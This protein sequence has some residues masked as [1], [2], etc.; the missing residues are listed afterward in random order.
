V[1][2]MPQWTTGMR[3]QRPFAEGALNG[4]N[5]PEVRVPDRSRYGR[6]SISWSRDRLLC[7]LKSLQGA[8]ALRSASAT[9]NDIPLLQK[10]SR[11]KEAQPRRGFHLENLG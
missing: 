10:G 8:E 9:R 7:C 6:G 3:K 5:R 4:S 1:R 2:M 11:R